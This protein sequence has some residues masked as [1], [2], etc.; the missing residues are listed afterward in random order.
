MTREATLMSGIILIAVP[1]AQYGGYF[2]L[3]ALM[4]GA[5][6]IWTI[7]CARTFS[8]RAMPTRP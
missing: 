6:A 8:G 5:A 7:R 3:T 4:T 1:G 2:L